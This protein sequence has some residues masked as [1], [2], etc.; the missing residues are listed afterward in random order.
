MTLPTFPVPAPGFHKNPGK[1]PD[2]VPPETEVQ[3]QWACGWIDHHIYRVKDLRWNL[4]GH[5][6]D[7]GAVRAA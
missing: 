4:T 5:R 1:F 3:V 2:T 7:V 6:F